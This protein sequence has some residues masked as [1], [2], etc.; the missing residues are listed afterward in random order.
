MILIFF[1]SVIIL[2][3]SFF[4]EIFNLI[5]VMRAVILE[6]PSKFIHLLCFLVNLYLRYLSILVKL[7]LDVLLLSRLVILNFEHPPRRRHQLLI[8]SGFRHAFILI[9]CP[10]N[11]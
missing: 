7:Y 3:I 9:V 10:L 11:P 2:G 5:L 4:P 1:L 6:D 8:A